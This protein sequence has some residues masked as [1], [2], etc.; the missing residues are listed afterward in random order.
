MGN[1]GGFD[2]NKLEYEFGNATKLSVAKQH[3]DTSKTIPLVSEILNPK[4]IFLK[5]NYRKYFRFLKIQLS[6]SSS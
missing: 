6:L 2:A 5:S 4:N 1:N 3:I